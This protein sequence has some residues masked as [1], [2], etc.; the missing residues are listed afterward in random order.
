[1]IVYEVN[2]KICKKIFPDFY[3]WLIPHQK[4]M[5]TYGGFINSK[6]FKVESEVAD[7]ELLSV[8]YY[9]D[10]IESLNNYFTNYALGMQN[11]GIELFGDNF[12]AE[13]RIL[14]KLD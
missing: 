2:L 11:E 12:S 3:K 9:L 14:S 8:H 7:Y 5:L 6:I 4:K 1:M 10:N 13:R